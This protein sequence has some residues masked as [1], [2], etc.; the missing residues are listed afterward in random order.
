MTMMIDTEREIRRRVVGPADLLLDRLAE[1]LGGKAG[2]EAV[3]GTPIERGGVTVI[4]V[5]K[6]RWGFGGGGGRAGKAPEG[7]ETG[8]GSGGG[9]G[10]AV[11]PLGYI[12][13]KDGSV[14]F[15]P[16]RDPSA[17]M[18]MAP[19]MLAGGISALLVLRGVRRLLRG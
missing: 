14:E 2:V 13:I 19:V 3:F 8:E 10:V 7:Q 6:V 11:S 12:E 18:T 16:I 17:L 9:G 4:P 5:A 15:R 1:H